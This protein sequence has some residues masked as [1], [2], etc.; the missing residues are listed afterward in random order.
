M[1]TNFE[2]FMDS[3]PED[4]TEDINFDDIKDLETDNLLEDVEIENHN[5]RSTFT[6]EGNFVRIFKALTLIIKDK[7]NALHTIANILLKK[8]KKTDN[9]CL[10]LYFP[11]D[12]R[13]K[14]TQV[15]KAFKDLIIKELSNDLPN[16]KKF[17]QYAAKMAR[18][19]SDTYK[20]FS[21]SPFAEVY[22]Y[23]GPKVKKMKPNSS[24]NLDSTILPS[25]GKNNCVIKFSFQ[26]Q[27]KSSVKS[28][29]DQIN[30]YLKDVE[31]VHPEFYVIENFGESCILY[32]VNENGFN[33]NSFKKIQ[34]LYDYCDE[35]P[36]NI[37]GDHN[38]LE[39]CKSKGLKVFKQIFD[40]LDFFGEKCCSS[41]GS[42]KLSS[43]EYYECCP[44]TFN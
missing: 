37:Q 9:I 41:N 22:N 19:E 14:I 27:D 43:I 40:Q 11:R 26:Q 16:V 5:L 30:D 25:E 7:K 23:L 33:D 1:S 38:D 6:V 13:K 15:Q 8:I 17:P 44:S 34:E 20:H 32:L 18:D 24:N 29:R 2:S 12:K 4:F 39:K 21:K 42:Y 35:I 28:V 31:C 10:Y 36:R 3:D